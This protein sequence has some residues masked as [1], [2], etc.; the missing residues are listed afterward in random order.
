MATRMT[1]WAEALDLFEENLRQ[2]KKQLAGLDLGQL[3][4]SP[5]A[6]WPPLDLV[7]EPLPVELQARGHALFEESEAIQRRLKELK[8]EIPIG[9]QSRRRTHHPRVRP[10]SRRLIRD[11]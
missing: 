6:S 2:A 1:S 8:S 11:L 5:M 7:N 10:P 3:E 4:N 9:V